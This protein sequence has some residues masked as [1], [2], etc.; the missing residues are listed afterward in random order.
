MAIVSQFRSGFLT[1]LC[2]LLDL[3]GMVHLVVRIQQEHQHKAQVNIWPIQ[4]V[5]QSLTSSG[6][7]VHRICPSLHH[8]C[9]C[10]HTHTKHSAEVHAEPN[11]WWIRFQVPMKGSI[12][13]HQLIEKFLQLQCPH[14][15][16]HDQM[17]WVFMSF[18]Y[19]TTPIWSKKQNLNNINPEIANYHGQRN[20]G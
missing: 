3:L 10:T 8:A 20:I 1:K 12:W 6:D 5:Y 2:H 4:A 11:M 13:I 15:L 14:S 17:Q 19:R 16:P 9:Y 18:R 7:F